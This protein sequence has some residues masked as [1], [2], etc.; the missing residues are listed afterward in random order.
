VIKLLSRLNR[1]IG[2]YSPNVF[3]LGVV[4]FLTDVSS[5]MIFTLIPL[6]LC[7][8]LGSAATV[9][10][11]V[12]GISESADSLFRIFSGWFSDRTASASL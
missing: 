5:E 2:N 10:G 8:V 11:L 4:S 9:V 7:N 1:K 3:F 12:G 6:F